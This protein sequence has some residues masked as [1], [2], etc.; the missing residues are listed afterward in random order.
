MSE[1]AGR[2]RVAG[3]ARPQAEPET[4]DARPQAELKEGVGM[5]IKINN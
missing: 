3:D 4:G 2:D 1:A 5:R